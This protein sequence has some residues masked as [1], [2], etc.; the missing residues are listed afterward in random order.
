MR[1]D[2]FRARAGWAAEPA[3]QELSFSVIGPAPPGGDDM[4][5]LFVT[6][7]TTFLH[8]RVGQPWQATFRP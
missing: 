1:P 4:R 3:R 5:D 7:K 2:T 8:L 6:A